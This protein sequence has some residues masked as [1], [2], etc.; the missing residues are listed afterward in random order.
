MNNKENQ[1]NKNNQISSFDNNF[2]K[3]RIRMRKINIKKSKIE[4]HSSMKKIKSEKNLILKKNKRIKNQINHKIYGERKES[5]KN[6]DSELN[7]LSYKDALKLDQRTYCQY[8][9]SLLK[10]KQSILFSFYPYKDY[11]SQIIKS[12]LFFFFYASDITINA[13]FFN[14]DT[15]HKIYNNSG[16]FNIVYQLP[17]IIYSYL[18]SSGINFIIEYLSLTDEIIIYIKSKKILSTRIKTKI[19]KSI[20][21]KFCFFFI[22]TFI[23][24]FIFWYYISCF[25][26]IYE[27]TQI[28]LIKDSLLSLILSSI[29]PFYKSLIPGIFRIPALRNKRCNKSC[30]YKLSQIIEYF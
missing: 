25:C 2:H 7:S 11:N 4:I 13:L 24:L 22:I 28:H 12:F 3:K 6:T 14:D 20:E 8:Y 15:M 29:I 1:I 16:S 9:W 19:I 30:I 26:C 10:K 18:I 17:Q 27:N 23:L 5:Y 21:I